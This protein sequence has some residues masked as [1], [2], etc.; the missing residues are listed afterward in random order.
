MSKPTKTRM[1]TA[2]LSSGVAYNPVEVFLI[3]AFGIAIFRGVEIWPF[4]LWL[5]F[6][7]AALWTLLA[8]T[9]E[10]Q[11]E[12]HLMVLEREA[13]M[14]D[15][16]FGAVFLL[17]LAGMTVDYG[18]QFGIMFVLAAIQNLRYAAL[19]FD[20]LREEKGNDGS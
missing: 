6:A 14:T 11:S 5:S 1:L 20:W 9:Q 16:V 4:A 2:A 12:A 18:L 13:Y 19:S 10:A 8:S 15:F 3:V 17:T 7:A